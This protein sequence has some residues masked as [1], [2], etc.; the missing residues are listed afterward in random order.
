MILTDPYTESETWGQGNRDM[1]HSSAGTQE[2]HG[3][4]LMKLPAELRNIIYRHVLGHALPKLVLPRWMQH[5]HEYS[6]GHPVATGHFTASSF[7]SLQ[8]CNRQL[9]HEASYIL[10]QVCHFSFNIAPTHA[11]FLDGCL[12]SGYP[13]REIQDKSYIHRITNI[14]LKA[15]WDCYDWATIRRFFWKNWRDATSMVCR[16]L[17]GFSSLRRL[18]LDWRVPNPR[19]YLQPTTQ[20]WLSISPIFKRLQARR[21]N[22]RMEVLAWQMIPGSIPLV[23]LEIRTSLEGYTKELLEARG[24]LQYTQI[25]LANVGL[26]HY[27]W[28]PITTSR[29]EK[30]SYQPP[31][32]SSRLPRQPFVHPLAYY[33]VHDGSIVAFSDNFSYLLT[34]CQSL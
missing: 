20:Q 3:F 28:S 1:D 19:E 21:P 13:T 10:Y 31:P 22:I 23:H 2:G 16:Q 29:S 6:I 17:L 32:D 18:T 27:Q 8:L 34:P 24:R 30:C 33:R 15:N 5:L 4:P 9:Y 25:S 11:T 14:V 26:S 12:L 7:A